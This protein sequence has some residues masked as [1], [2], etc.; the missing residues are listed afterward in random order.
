MSCPRII[1]YPVL[2]AAL[3]G[4]MA[5]RAEP[6]GEQE[7]KKY[8]GV[9]S[10]EPLPIH[11]DPSVT[12]DF[13]IVY[14]RAPRLKPDGGARWTEVGDPRTME[15]GADLVLLHP[16]GSE[17]VLVPVQGNESIADPFV[18]IDGKSVYFAK[19]HDAKNHK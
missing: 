16:D 15:P 10:M 13:D 6:P 17:E 19:F 12:Y 11:E 5:A 1:F 9:L 7:R 14:V 18:S 3:V 2:L 4:A 8:D